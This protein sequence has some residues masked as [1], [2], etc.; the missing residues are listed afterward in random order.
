[1]D[2]WTEGKAITL[3]R[4]IYSSEKFA[5]KADE[6]LNTCKLWCYYLGW[7]QDNPSR[8]NVTFDQYLAKLQGGEYLG[9]Y[10]MGKTEGQQTDT[11]QKLKVDPTK[12]LELVFVGTPRGSENGEPYLTMYRGWGERVGVYVLSNGNLRIVMV[13]GIIVNT[14]ST[15]SDWLEYMTQNSLS[16]GVWSDSDQ[17]NGQPFENYKDVNSLKYG[18]KGKIITSLT[19]IYNWPFFVLSK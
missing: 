6:R 16:V 2:L 4:Q 5:L 9:F 8:S 17:K 3:N 15:L 1:M 10:V 12:P 11:L 14:S 18:A 7:Q 13:D 19:S